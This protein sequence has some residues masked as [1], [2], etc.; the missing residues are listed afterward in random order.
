MMERPSLSQPGGQRQKSFEEDVKMVVKPNAQDIASPPVDSDNNLPEQQ[1]TRAPLIHHV[2][3]FDLE[4]Q[5][6]PHAEEASDAPLTD[7]LAATGETLKRQVV[8]RQTSTGHAQNEPAAN[9][10]VEVQEGIFAKATSKKVG[11]KYP[12]QKHL[13]YAKTL[14]SFDEVKRAEDDKIL[15]GRL[16]AFQKSKA[17]QS[18][19]GKPE[20][21][22]KALDTRRDDRLN[23]KPDEHQRGTQRKQPD[24]RKRLD[25]RRP[26]ERKRIEERRQPDNRRD[27]GHGRDVREDRGNKL[28]LQRRAKK[29]QEE[30]EERNFMSRMAQRGREFLSKIFRKREDEK[31][32][33]EREHKEQRLKLER[34]FRQAQQ[35]SVKKY[36]D[37]RS[38]LGKAGSQQPVRRDK[39]NV[40][41]RSQ[42]EALAKRL[43]LDKLFKDQQAWLQKRYRDLRVQLDR[44]LRERQ[45]K[46]GQ[47]A[48][49]RQPVERQ[50]VE[51]Q[52]V[53]RTRRE[54]VHRER[55][56][57]DRV[58]RD[59]ETVTR[60]ERTRKETTQRETVRRET[61]RREQQH[62]EHR[63][64]EDRSRRESERRNQQERQRHD[65]RRDSGR[66]DDRRGGW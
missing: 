35:R 22:T 1:V 37:E 40:Q 55:T 45:R 29:L 51:R 38:R 16:E 43:K 13:E 9:K 19:G 42:L 26:D 61:A 18:S 8:L 39:Q 36:Q 46:L 59:R 62:R 3:R 63:A 44:Q 47:G 6:S 11:E 27:R 14:G 10:K 23:R 28:E 12:S 41:Q 15:K 30:L 7:E 58:R 53:E 33:A 4:S 25:E 66:R 52:R 50:R 5:V 54:R 60:Q 2:S 24:E 32:R 21:A 49:G 65:S 17:R 31:A 34:D 57:Q 20:Q 64:R 48:G 56:R